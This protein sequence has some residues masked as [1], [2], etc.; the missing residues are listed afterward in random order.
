MNNSANRRL[1]FT[2]TATLDS[3]FTYQVFGINCNIR[4]L[5]FLSALIC[6]AQMKQEEEEDQKR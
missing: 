3:S 5:G 1:T 2:K 6:T 4:N